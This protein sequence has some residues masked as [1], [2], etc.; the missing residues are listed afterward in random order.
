[1]DGCISKDGKLQVKTKM[2]GCAP[3]C[4]DLRENKAAF[5]FFVN[6][7]KDKKK[8]YKK[9]IDIYTVLIHNHK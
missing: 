7:I 3:G 6:L 4:T 5:C 2:L 1:M 8:E 9:D